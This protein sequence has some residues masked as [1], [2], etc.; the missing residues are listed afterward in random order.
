LRLIPAV[1]AMLQDD[2][3][4]FCF[5]DKIRVE[6]IQEMKEEILADETV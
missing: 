5:C 3:I 6:R 1:H 4:S 2:R